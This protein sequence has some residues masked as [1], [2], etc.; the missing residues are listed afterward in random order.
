M[1]LL[2]QQRILVIDDDE[3]ARES[4]QVLLTRWGYQVSL[5]SS[6]EEGVEILR[7]DPHDL[8][9][10]DLA[11]P[12]IGGLEV[13]KLVREMDPTL[14]CIM[15]TGHA[16]LQHAVE[17]MKLGSYDFLAKPFSPDELKMTVNRGLERRFLELETQRLRSEKEHMEANFVT[18]VSHQMRSPLAAVRQLLEVVETRSLGP[19]PENYQEIVG[20]V[21]S[22]LDELIQT[23]NA[24]LSMSRI[25]ESGIAERKAPVAVSELIEVLGQRTEL[26]AKAAGQQ[27]VLEQLSEDLTI[28]VDVESLIEALYNITSNAVKYN[29]QGG[30][31][32]IRVIREPRRL[33]IMV[34]DQGPGVPET[35]QPYLFDDFFRSK[36]PELKAKPGTGL[37]LSIARRVVKAH[38]G[39]ISV[40]SKPGEGAVFLVSL[41]L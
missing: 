37:G 25:A 31:V 6:G 33:D 12:G 32:T 30:V 26:D 19:L 23:M 40:K 22:R 8:V 18:M 9:L 38:G 17:A 39:E 28:D 36:S 2:A 1:T 13:L 27:V 16:T 5:A 24:W 15:V 7:H 3:V 20:R 21:V 10:V 41:P 35:E 11:M 29:R 34:E 14:I 4:A